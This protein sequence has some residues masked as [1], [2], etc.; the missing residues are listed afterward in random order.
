[1]ETVWICD[2]LAIAVADIDF[3][4][5]ELAASDRARE[6]G[7]RLELRNVEQQFSG[8]IYS[9]PTVVLTAALCRIDLLESAAGAGDRMHWHPT[10]IDGEPDDRVL[11]SQ[12]SEDPLRWLSVHLE[13]VSAILRLAGVTDLDHYENDVARIRH[14]RAEIVDRTAEGLARSRRSWA[15][16]EHDERGLAAI[17]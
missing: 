6:R 15:P 4:D 17:L 8:T 7:V 14:H 10:M 13:D 5:P 16:V 3:L 12:L 11:D 9:S 1:M 2:Q